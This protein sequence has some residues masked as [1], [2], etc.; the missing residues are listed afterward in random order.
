M[1]LIR[2][3]REAGV[4]GAGG[5]GFPTHVKLDTSV[6]AF[7]VNGVE[8]E[9]LL[10]TDKYL[11]RHY[12]EEL[13]ESIETVAEHLGAKRKIIGIKSKYK[14]EHQALIQA[15]EKT[16]STI[17][18][19]A[20]DSFYPAGDEQMLIR[21]AL[22]ETVP[23]GG[24][25]LNVGAVVS[26]VATLLDVQKAIRGIPVTER[27][28]TV[29]GAV[30]SPT[31]IRV[32][33]GTAIKDCLELAGG[34]IPS[35]FSVIMGGPM[36]GAECKGT[37]I[38]KTYVTK[39]L[40]GL[41]VLPES[42]T[43]IQRKRLPYQHIINRAASSC[44]QCRMCTDLCPRF[45]NGHPLYPHKVMRAVGNGEASLS[46]YESALLC[47]ECGVCELYACPMGLS[48]KTVNQ[49]VKRQLME[50]G[51][52]LNLNKDE[53]WTPHEMRNYRKVD[54]HR[55]VARIDLSEY[56][57]VHLEDVVEFLPNEVHISLKQHIGR[58]AESVVSDGERVEAG[59]CVAEIPES[60]LGA[61]IHA[62]IS[63]IVSLM[64]D[65]IVIKKEGEAND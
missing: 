41:V 7:I 48:P 62:S 11:M 24:I 20:L 55:L 59:Q 49:R 4:V 39:T 46:A 56:E 58:P 10:E 36:M 65:G 22:E 52:K 12:A 64:P 47:C 16:Q 17:E 61:R 37:D 2:A 18:V 63:G 51:I 29:T 33:V 50:G 25:P 57:S 54:T 23:P 60:S 44:I 3:I 14:R 27:V 13:I 32:P 9:P 8:C 21:E 5:A 45:L 15:I 19:K 26:N 6:E 34:V 43:I 40:G 31:L 38:D 35:D 42:H 28:I 1:E 30:K 53:E